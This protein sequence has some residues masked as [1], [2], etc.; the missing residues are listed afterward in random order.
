M[1]AQGRAING[2]AEGIG[3]RRSKWTGNERKRSYR[4]GN[5]R[6]AGTTEGWNPTQTANAYAHRHTDN[7][8]YRWPVLHWEK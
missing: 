1:N 8:R 3:N 4:R 2:R 6:A 7:D 5:Q